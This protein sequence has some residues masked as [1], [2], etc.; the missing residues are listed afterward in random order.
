MREAASQCIR[1]PLEMIHFPN[2]PIFGSEKL[3]RPIQPSPQILRPLHQLLILVLL[4]LKLPLPLHTNRT[5][6]LLT[7]YAIQILQLSFP[8]SSQERLISWCGWEIAHATFVRGRWL[9]DD[10]CC[11][12]FVGFL[13]IWLCDFVDGEGGGVRFLRCGRLG[14][15]LILGLSFGVPGRWLCHLEG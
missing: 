12:G 13:A 7:T 4:H 10:W 3:S 15:G 11:V 6:Y 2:I 5:P 14:I 8:H 1:N 9:L